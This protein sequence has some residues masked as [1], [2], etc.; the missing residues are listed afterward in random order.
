[1]SA[2]P[3]AHPIDI[4]PSDIDFMGHVNNARYLGWVQD[5]VLAHWQ[6]FAPAEAV[7]ERAWVALKHEITYR[8]PA[9]LEDDV[10]ART[11]LESTRGARAFYHT[12]IERGGEVLAEVKS[13]WCCIDAKSLRPARIGEEIARHFFPP[14]E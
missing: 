14:S 2:K 11:V 9:F 4:Q 6:K 13:S 1:M 12:V 10:I 8:K 7:A 3:Y 5:A